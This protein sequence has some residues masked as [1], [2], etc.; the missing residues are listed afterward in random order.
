MIRVQVGF[1]CQGIRSGP[2][3]R[4]EVKDHTG[5]QPGVAPG[6]LVRLDSCHQALVELQRRS[7]RLLRTRPPRRQQTAARAG[8]RI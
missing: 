4:L 3:F 1:V 5:S 8:Y 6:T 2:G 7:Q